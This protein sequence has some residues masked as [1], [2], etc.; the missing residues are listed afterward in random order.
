MIENS[1]ASF[2][3]TGHANV[4]IKQMESSKRLW[5]NCSLSLFQ[6]EEPVPESAAQPTGKEP[7]PTSTSPAP[8]AP[9]NE[10]EPAHVDEI[11]EQHSVAASEATASS[12]ASKVFQNSQQLF[13]RLSLQARDAAVVAGQKLDQAALSLGAAV[14]NYAIQVRLHNRADDHSFPAARA[15]MEHTFA[16]M[17]HMHL[18][19]ELFALLST[20]N[21]LGARAWCPRTA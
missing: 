15:R 5:R 13:Q 4:D 1:T 10:Q 6:M 9:T 11:D 21:L 20:T 7:E 2:A 19:F 17:Q 3:G 16:R 14:D 12:A 8:A 18:S